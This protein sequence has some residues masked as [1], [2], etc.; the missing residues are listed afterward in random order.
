[1]ERLL[2]NRTVATESV[3]AMPHVSGAPLTPRN[4]THK[5]DVPA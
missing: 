2:A 4:R 3:R 1:M 5:H